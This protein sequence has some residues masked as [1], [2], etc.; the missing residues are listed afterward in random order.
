MAYSVVLAVVAGQ[1]I[2]QKASR[3]GANLVVMD[4]FG[5]TRLRQIAFGG[6]T[7]H[8]MS[9]ANLPVLLAC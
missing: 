3:L 7:R 2:L 9:E 4:A 5:H 6:A 1:R 8:V